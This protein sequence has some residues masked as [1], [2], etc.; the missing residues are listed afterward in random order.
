MEQRAEIRKMIPHG[1]VGR[2]AE[3]AGVSKASV[4]KWFGNNTDSTRIEDAVLIVLEEVAKS[5]VERRDKAKRL[6]EQ[7]N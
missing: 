5:T 7:M 3:Q 4:S 6:M 1:M 2:I